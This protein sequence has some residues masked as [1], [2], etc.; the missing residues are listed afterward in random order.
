TGKVGVV[1]YD[2]IPENIEYVRSGE[3]VAAIAQDPFG[4]GFDSV[5]YLYNYLVAG[6]EPP[7]DFIPV[8]LDV[9][10]PDNV[11]ELYPN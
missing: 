9:L 6:Q 10:T 3:I 2:H 1:A 8:K 7:A 4:Q 5:V 11:N